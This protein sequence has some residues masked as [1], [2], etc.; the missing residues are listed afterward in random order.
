VLQVTRGIGVHLFINLVAQIFG[1][2]IVHAKPGG[3]EMVNLQG[4]NL[5]V[6]GFA[7]SSVEPDC[8]TRCPVDNSL[9]SKFAEY[10]LYYITTPEAVPNAVQGESFQMRN[11]VLEKFQ[12]NFSRMKEV[13]RNLIRESIN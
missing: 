12:S 1:K 13:T 2:L 8:W 5:V 4:P 9:G 11:V 10:F 7:H 3:C 6:P